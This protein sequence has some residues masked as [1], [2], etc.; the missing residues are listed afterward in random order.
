MR[1]KADLTLLSVSIIWGVAFLAQYYAAEFNSIYLF[2]GFGFLIAAM[3]LTLLQKKRTRISGRQWLWMFIAGVVLFIASFF[4]QI[5]LFTTELA[6]AGFLT[7]LYTVFTPFVIFLIFREKPKTLDIMAV[8]IAVVGA[9]LLSTGGKMTFHLGDIYE[10]SGAIFWALHIVI[11]GKFAMTYDAVTFSAGQFFFSAVLN[12]I[13]G[14]FVEP[15]SILFEPIFIG[16]LLFRAVFSITIGYT[17][18]VWGQ[19]HTPPTDAAL[20]LSLEA[21]FAAITGWV[22]LGQFLA[23]IQIFGCVFIFGAVLLSQLKVFFPKLKVT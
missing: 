16:S 13:V 9:F 4:Q 18:Q 6:N 2:N 10:A 15:I 8:S 3:L 19:K 20:L 12:I 1:L 14:L 11:I 22:V 23:P 7:S 17:L 21:V 5:G